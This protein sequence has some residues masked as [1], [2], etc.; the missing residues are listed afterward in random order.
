MTG[1]DKIKG[2]HAV[3]AQSIS[4]V[5]G[6]IEADDTEVA[7]AFGLALAQLGGTAE[8]IDSIADFAKRHLTN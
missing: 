3:I 8:G 4:D 5:R 2:C 1:E 7:A 6:A